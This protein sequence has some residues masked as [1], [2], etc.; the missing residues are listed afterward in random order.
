MVR[1]S[2]VRC[3]FTSALCFRCVF[4]VFFAT[5]YVVAVTLYLYVVFLRCYSSRKIAVPSFQHHLLGMNCHHAYPN[6]AIIKHSRVAHSDPCHAS[7]SKKRLIYGLLRSYCHF[8]FRVPST[9]YPKGI[10][11][12]AFESKHRYP[13]FPL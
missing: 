3:F 7:S 13:R 6:L 1:S 11:R 10:T 8:V 12:Q 4:Y 5:G 9:K 2:R